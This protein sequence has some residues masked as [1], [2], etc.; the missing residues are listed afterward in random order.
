MASDWPAGEGKMARRVRDHDWSATP[1][2]PIESWPPELRSTV[3]L[4]L[5]HGFPMIVLWGRDL[6]Q[7]YNDGYA[8]IM[9]DKHPA[10][11]GRPTREC[12]PE[13]WDI[14]APIY[15]RVGA[16][17]TLTFEDKLFPIARHGP[18]ED[19]W[20][21]LT[22]SPLREG[23][24][25]AGVLVTLFE[26]TAGHL[27][28][29]H[30]EAALRIEEERAFL[31][32]LSDALR[33]LE[34][35]AE[36]E[37]EAARILGDSLDAAWTYYGE[38]T[39]TPQQL[40]TVRASHVRAGVPGIVGTYPV[41]S[42]AVL[43]RLQAGH[44]LAIEDISESPL[45][46]AKAR[47]RW[48]KIGMR[49][50]A[51][52]PIV[53]KGNLIAAVIVADTKPR[54][55]SGAIGLIEETAERTWAAVERADAEAALRESRHRLQFLVAELQHRVRNILTVV[56]S[57]F[58]RTIEAG[59]TL[60]DVADHFK[61]RLDSL[62]RTQVVVT[63][64]LGGL[65]DLENLIR[66]ELLSV[67]VSDGPHLTIDGPDIALTSKEAESIGLAIHELTTNAL[68]YG[69]LKNSTGKLDIRWTANMSYG[70]SERLDLIWTEQGVSAVAV[71]PTRRGFG[72]EL[73]EEALPYRL[74]AETKLEFR[75][76]GIRC[77]ISLPMPGQDELAVP[78]W[79]EA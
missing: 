70:E 29:A 27:A 50:I 5:D 11:L 38:L 2:G 61:G 30:R 49:S 51:A 31:L 3:D 36:I 44:P 37:G 57:V 35:A 4:M 77:T 17:E 46:N 63:Q 20:F 67:G 18:I 33:P 24:D 23:R 9:A 60:D 13:I 14:N 1:I 64:S 79:K 39:R 78:I 55:W 12:W 43:D 54:D 15:D 73:I 28:A 26:T 71:K 22:Y 72:S 6:I 69:A 19:A 66:D 59:G 16:G 65:I 34:S 32:K 48:E 56:R 40:M 10:G 74:G 58:G 25:V 45:F 62:A 52:V 75:G 8:V 76:G 7:I 68:K 47:A 41:D 53:K 21:T 42:T